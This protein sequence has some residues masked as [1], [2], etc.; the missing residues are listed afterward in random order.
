MEV[1][2]DT[3]EFLDLQLK[4]VKESKEISVDMFAKHTDSFTYVLPSTCFPK[5]NTKSIPKGVALGLGR[6]SDSDQ[7]FEKHSAEYQNY[8]ITWDYKPGKVKK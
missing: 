3:L 4:I 7:K 8:L 2:T 6:I 1:A 5:N